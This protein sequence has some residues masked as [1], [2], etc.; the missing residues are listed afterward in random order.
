VDGPLPIRVDADRIA[1]VITNYIGNALKY[2]PANTPV[3]VQF[4]TRSGGGRI[5]AA[6]TDS[7]CIGVRSGIGYTPAE[8]QRIWER[9]YQIENSRTRREPGIGLGLGLYISK[10]IIEIHGDHVGVQSMPPNG[11]TF[12][13]T[14][15]LAR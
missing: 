3:L 10:T 1:Q 6:Q 13:F 9:F 12:W 11:S 8:Q 4:R 2:S 5:Q 15:P 7:A 14:L